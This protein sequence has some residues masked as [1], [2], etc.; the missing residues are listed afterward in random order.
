M[1]FLGY[2]L[3]NQ[4]ESIE[5]KNPALLPFPDALFFE[6]QIRLQ[7]QDDMLRIEANEPER[8]YEEI[9][10][11]EIEP[12]KKAYHYQ[13]ISLTEEHT[14]LPNVEQI[15]NW[16]ACGEVY[17]LNYCVGHVVERFNT[18]PQT[19]FEWM[20][21]HA[22]APFLGFFQAGHYG[23]VSGSPERFLKRSG[24]MLISQPI[25]GTAPR[26]HSNSMLD[27]ENALRLRQS[28]KEQAENLMIVDLV[29][30]DLAKSCIP[31]TVKVHELFG[32][33]SFPQVHQMIS[34]VVGT[35]RSEVHF[36]QSLANAFPM[37]SMTGAPKIRAMQLIDSLEN[38]RRGP[39]SGAFGYI[40]PQG[41]FD[42]NVLIRSLFTNSDTKQAMF[43][44]GS[45]I[46]FDADPE[47][48]WR[49]CQLKLRG[50]KAMLEQ[51]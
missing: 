27:A 10:A 17:E 46:T 9:L 30:N 12:E 39:F 37:G 11:F 33:Y 21:Q 41:Q 14:Y 48:E 51:L 47:Q 36:S 23:I 43:A 13:P 3:K 19:A 31:G 45:A 44:A 16:I 15:R 38:F 22:P 7:W 49:E 29:R 8:V 40:D 50:I 1:G 42:F 2:D 35:K 20:R 25:K 6:P 28:E 26:N 4:L 5:S 18:K 34:T 32:I 24:N